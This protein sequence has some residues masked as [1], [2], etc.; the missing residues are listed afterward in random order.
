MEHPSEKQHA[1]GWSFTP[2]TEEEIETARA[3]SMTVEQVRS[4]RGANGG[5]T[6]QVASTSEWKF[7]GYYSEQVRDEYGR[8]IAGAGVHAG[9]ESRSKSSEQL[10][11]EALSRSHTEVQLSEQD[12]K[13]AQELSFNKAY[14]AAKTAIE[15]GEDPNRAALAAT[16]GVPLADAELQQIAKNAV[17]AA[18]VDPFDNTAQSANGAPQNNEFVQLFGGKE[19]LEKLLAAFLGVATLRDELSNENLGAANDTGRQLLDRG[20]MLT[21]S[22]AAPPLN[23]FA[24]QANLP[25]FASQRGQGALMG[26]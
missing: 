20:T 22:R 5:A 19:A 26:A 6:E 18:D 2:Y 4:W 8:D 15:K 14:Q 17:T 24:P 12:R 25:S 16:Q 9:T 3:T 13:H 7:S 21:D 11:A 23:G 10:G 1:G